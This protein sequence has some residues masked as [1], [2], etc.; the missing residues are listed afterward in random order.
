V[1][2]LRAKLIATDGKIQKEILWFSV[3]SNSVCSGY[4]GDYGNFHTTYHFDGNVYTT[5]PNEKTKKLVTL[6]SLNN[7]KT[8]HQLYT[9]AFSNKLSQ[10]HS[11]L[12][13]LKKLDAIVNIDTRAH[14]NHIGVHF[15][16]I[17]KDRFDLLDKMLITPTIIEAHFFFNCNPWIGIVLYS[18][19]VKE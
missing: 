4:C 5:Y 9:T 2:V 6:P 14:S 7:L 17:P 16:I 3:T 11:S 19:P 1:I 18:V 12:Y 10:A 15:F 13:N 8:F